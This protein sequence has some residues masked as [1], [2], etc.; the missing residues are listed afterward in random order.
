LAEADPHT[1]QS[2][3]RWTTNR[4]REHFVQTPAASP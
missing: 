1:L 3:D 4:A 2:F